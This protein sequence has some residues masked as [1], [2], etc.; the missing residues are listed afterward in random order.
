MKRM[1]FVPILALLTLISA[2][3]C[4]QIFTTSLGESLARDGLTISPNTS[5]DELINLAAS[6]EGADPDAAKAILAALGDKSDAD[7][8]ALSVAD[9]TEILNLA[10]TAS[11]DLPAVTTLLSQSG[12]SAD[13]DQLVS[14]IL[15]AFDTTVNLDAVLVVLSDT[16]ALDTAPIDSLVFASAVVLADAANALGTDTV[17]TIMAL[18]PAPTTAGDLTA[19]TGDPA[20]QDQI[21]TILNVAETLSTR[22]DLDSAS[23]GGFNIADLLNGTQGT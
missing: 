22:P 4:R 1:A 21:L 15:G 23:I 12:D 17:M 3:S 9:Q 2:V 7:V 13:T 20:V 16:E 8:A 14:D 19:Y 6:S 10:T 18:N 11:L 5:L